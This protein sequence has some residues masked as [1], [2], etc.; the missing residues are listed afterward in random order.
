MIKIMSHPPVLPVPALD[1]I[2][3]AYL[4]VAGHG[5][6]ASN[7]IKDWLTALAI[8][9][10]DQIWL[11]AQEKISIDSIR[12]L[13]HGLLLTPVQSSKRIAIIPAAQKL[14]P[15]ASHALLK[16]LEDPPPHAVL[17]L[18][19]EYEDQLL[20]TIVSRCQRW[21]LPTTSQKDRD[22]REWSIAA[23]R[24]SSYADR[25]ARAEG[26]AKGENF[27]EQFDQLLVAARTALFAHQ[28]TLIEMEQL[29]N[30]R[31][32]AATNVTPRLLADMALLSLGKGAA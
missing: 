1:R 5:R 31:A 19:A 11:P 10:I 21:H 8:E 32:L 9:S 12:E 18:V 3:S 27:L 24:A 28:L 6:D 2:A 14:S 26:W 20:G 23:L 16:T 17:I 15:E 7:P 30:Y 22:G 4:I 13:Q 25:L 29:L